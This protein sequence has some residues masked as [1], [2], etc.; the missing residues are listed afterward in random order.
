MV[1]VLVVSGSMAALADPRARAGLMGRSNSPMVQ[2]HAQAW[3][4]LQQALAA[5]SSAVERL[6]LQVVRCETGPRFPQQGGDD[7]RV[8]TAV[9]AGLAILACLWATGERLRRHRQQSRHAIALDELACLFQDRDRRWVATT[10]EAAIMLQHIA[11]LQE[12]LQAAAQEL[13]RMQAAGVPGAAGSLCSDGDAIR[14]PT[15]DQKTPQVG[16]NCVRKCI[17]C[18]VGI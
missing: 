7:H 12:Q 1:C 16:R 13:Q 2:V 18:W 5:G 11:A 8:V 17:E 15:N 10:E 3:D 14:S 6:R 9:A 4:Q